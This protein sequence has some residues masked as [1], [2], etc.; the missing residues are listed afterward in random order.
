MGERI[1]GGQ[2]M[3]RGFR[4]E[5]NAWMRDVCKGLTA[6]WAG[7]AVFILLVPLLVVWGSGAL[8]REALDASDRTRNAE[9]AAEEEQ[10]EAGA[11]DKIKTPRKIKVWREDLGKAVKVD[12]EEYVACVTASE[13]PSRIARLWNVTQLLRD[14]PNAP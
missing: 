3:R 10:G 2:A 11:A 7:L 8:G 1:K 4:T 5:R 13:M 12:F 9:S 14:V 6:V